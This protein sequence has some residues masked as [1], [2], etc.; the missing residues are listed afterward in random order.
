MNT[1]A[2][3]A[4]RDLLTVHS[5]EHRAVAA[6]SAADAARLAT[7]RAAVLGRVKDVQALLVS[8]FRP[9]T[10]SPDLCCA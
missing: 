3:L 2:A 6:T 1:L 5:V 9:S 7:L 10:S 8:A 4:P